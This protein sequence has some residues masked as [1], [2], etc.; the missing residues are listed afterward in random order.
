MTLA[1]PV[2][3]ATAAAVMVVTAARETTTES[4]GP[5][6][7]VRGRSQRAHPHAWRAWGGHGRTR[8]L[9][10]VTLVFERGPRA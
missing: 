4:Q 8:T 3:M 7:G 9:H 1:A 10:G 2:I 5:F 6:W